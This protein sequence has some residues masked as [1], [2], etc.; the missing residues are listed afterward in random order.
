MQSELDLGRAN[1]AGRLFIT[2][3]AL[4]HASL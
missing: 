1:F 3:L 2:V 4:V